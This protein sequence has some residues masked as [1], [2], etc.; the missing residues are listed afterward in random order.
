M[1]KQQVNKLRQL[2]LKLS[3]ISR[4]ISQL[5]DLIEKEVEFEIEK[6]N[7]KSEIKPLEIVSMLRSL[8]RLEAENFLKNSKQKTL[9]E[10]FIALGGSSV[11][12]KKPKQWLIERILW[13]IFDFKKGH[14]LLKK[15]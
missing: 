5:T 14:E 7:N 13:E 10:I 11:D 1:N 15:R 3:E 4:E 2:S 6:N 8:N 12:K 9:S